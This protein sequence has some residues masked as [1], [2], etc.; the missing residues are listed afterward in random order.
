M[1]LN[2]YL[3]RSGVA[4]RRQSDDLIRQATTEINGQ[5]CLNPAY[6][7]KPND[8]VLYDGRKISPVSEKIIIMLNKPKNVITTVQD[9]SGR[10]TVMDLL[11]IKTRV[12]PVGRLDKNTTGLLLLTNDGKLQHYLT[13]PSN[14][15]I[16]SYEAII[17]G[18]MDSKCVE[19]IGRGIY[20]GYN[21]YGKAEI[22]SQDTR[23]GRSKIVLRLKQGKK[24]EIRR[25]FFRLRKKLISLKRIGYSN[26]SL[27]SL[28]EG[29][30]RYLQNKEIRLLTRQKI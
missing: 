17:E 8:K 4:S 27:G 3:A 5:I 13:H 2:K 1:R 14:G 10:K 19:K 6:F 29:E 18:R 25:I 28:R 7:V 15:V 12:T 26:L 22:V 20:I 21:E 11:K 24:R 9:D 30:Y 23:K 16:K